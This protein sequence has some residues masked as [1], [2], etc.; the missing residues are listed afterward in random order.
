[1][2]ATNTMNPGCG[3]FSDD[4]PRQATKVQHGPIMG[5][6]S[7]TSVVLYLAIEEDDPVARKCAGHQG[8]QGCLKCSVLT[9]EPSTSSSDLLDGWRL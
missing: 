8:R 9:V 3:D 2:G 5:T 1:M 4:E 7:V 6:P